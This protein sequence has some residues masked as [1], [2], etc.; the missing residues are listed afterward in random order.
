M[1]LTDYIIFCMG[2]SKGWLK[3]AVI[4]WIPATLY[5]MD[6]KFIRNIVRLQQNVLLF[7]K[8]L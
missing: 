3:C 6:L 8:K 2:G 5:L 7:P 4:Q 1:S